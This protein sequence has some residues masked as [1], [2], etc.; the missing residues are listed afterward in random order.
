MAKEK[1]AGFTITL[2]YGRQGTKK[3]KFTGSVTVFFLEHTYHMLGT[4]VAKE[5]LY[6]SIQ[7]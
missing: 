6:N 4:L 7:A 3:D 1:G 5:F 2:W